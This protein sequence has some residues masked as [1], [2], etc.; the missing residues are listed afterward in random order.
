MTDPTWYEHALNERGLTIMLLRARIGHIRAAAAPLRQLSAALAAGFK[1][2]QNEALESINA[3]LREIDR[4]PQTPSGALPES[5]RAV[6]LHRGFQHGA[7]VTLNE[8]K[9]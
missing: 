3:L 8:E 1:H 7:G 9:Q 6:T 5:P 4:D 2:D